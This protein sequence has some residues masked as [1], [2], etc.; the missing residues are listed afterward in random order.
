LISTGTPS[1]VGIASNRFLTDGDRIRVE[2]DHLGFI[3]NVA[4]AEH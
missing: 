3:E 1:G 2:I 4:R